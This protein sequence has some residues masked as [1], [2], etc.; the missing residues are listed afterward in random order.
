MAQP[1]FELFLTRN[2]TYRFRL[3][4]P[5]HQILATSEEFRRKE[6]AIN[7]IH[8]IKRDVPIADIRDET[9]PEE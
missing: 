2:G 4:S 8:Q 9:S 3:R 5:S 1:H 7:C 6:Y